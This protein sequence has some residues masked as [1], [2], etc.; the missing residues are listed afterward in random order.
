MGLRFLPNH[1]S[2]HNLPAIEFRLILKLCR[3]RRFY[4]RIGLNLVG[5]GACTLVRSLIHQTRNALNT[6]DLLLCQSRKLSIALDLDN[7]TG[8][9]P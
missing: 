4:T 7:R 9:V 2:K 6:L 5:H 3:H 1:R 8:S